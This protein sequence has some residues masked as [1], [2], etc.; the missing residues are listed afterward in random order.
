MKVSSW[1][2]VGILA[3]ALSAC[4]KPVEGPKGDAG[5]AGPAGAQGEQGPAGAAGPPGPPGPPAPGPSNAGGGIH[6]VRAACSVATCVAECE[7]DEIVVSAWC[8]A[9]RN[10][11]NFPTERSATC[12]G[13][14]G[15]GNNPLIAVCVKSSA[16]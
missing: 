13:G 8:G 6:V 1:V 12:R 11:T 2:V 3:L 9:A 14:R 10:T 4:G 15:P 16:P 5:P 7:A